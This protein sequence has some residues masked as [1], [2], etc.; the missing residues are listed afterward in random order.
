MKRKVKQ[1]LTAAG[2]AFAP[3]LLLLAAVLTV[4]VRPIGPE[5]SNIGLAGINSYVFRQLG[6]HLLWYQI[7]DWLGAMAVLV[8]VGFALLGLWQLV[9]RRAIQGVDRDILA[10]G[11]FYLLVVA[12]YLLFEVFPVNYR[13]ILLGGRLEASFPSSHTMVVVCIMV[14]AMMQFQIRIK[15]G[16]ARMAAQLAS[17]AVAAVT[18]LGR[19]ISG[20]HWF[21]DI[22]GGLLLGAA[23]LLLYKAAILQIEH[24]GLRQG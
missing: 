16:F 23:L 15:N 6:V 22:V 11:A 2:I 18:V 12:A 5:Q 19:L 20:V 4:D 21:T 3:F 17:A 10:L 9:R 13:P 1:T 7:T 8:A 24:A 14:A